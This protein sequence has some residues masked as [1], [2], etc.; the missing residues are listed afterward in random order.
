MPN[1][2]LG[3]AW[4][5]LLTVTAVSA[6]LLQ[7]CGGDGGGGSTVEAPSPGT[8]T[9]G[10]EA[11]GRLRSGEASVEVT[12]DLR[13]SF[14]VPL[15]GDSVYSPPPGG[16]ALSYSDDRGNFFG[17]GGITFTGSEETSLELSVT[18]TVGRESPQLFVSTAGECTV[19]ISRA[20]ATGVQGQAECDDL[21]NER[22]A[23]VASAVFSAST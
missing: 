3:R 20:D 2:V 14:T 23:I 9:Q 17:I 22:R 16:M 1:R 13:S 15:I 19:S 18:I 4:P 8:E 21:A 10:P 7:G 5:R 11:S 12:G 6:V